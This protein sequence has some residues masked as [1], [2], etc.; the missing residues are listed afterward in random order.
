MKHIIDPY[1]LSMK[2]IIDPWSIL[3]YTQCTN[4]KI[5]IIVSL[6]LTI[7]FKLINIQFTT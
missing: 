5:S 2:H 6:L 1:Y 7:F 4:Q 3:F